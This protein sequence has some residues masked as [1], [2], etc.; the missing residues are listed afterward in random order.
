MHIRIPEDSVRENVEQFVALM[1]RIRL[2]QPS[3]QIPLKKVFK[4]WVNKGSGRIV[5]SDA[6]P[7]SR[8]RKSDEWKAVSFSYEYN[9]KS[10]EI[11]FLAEDPSASNAQFSNKEM[12]TGAFKVFQ[13]TMK[14]FSEFSL[15]LKGPSDLDTKITVLSKMHIESQLSAEDRNMLF[16]AWHAADRS[17]AELLLMGKPVGAYL[18]RQD[19]FTKILEEQLAIQLHRKV[20]CFTVTYVERPHKF[21]DLT[22]VHVDGMWLV[23]NDDPQLKGKKFADIKDFLHQN[24]SLLRFP[25]FRE[26]HRGIA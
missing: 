19:P 11:V 20:K 4:A 1:R 14:T 17:E 7:S 15:R 21:C 23:Y 8:R 3:H 5:F 9:P 12:A 26:N 25:F 18:F 6:K 2:A 16:D 24:K 13:K 10:G 22:L